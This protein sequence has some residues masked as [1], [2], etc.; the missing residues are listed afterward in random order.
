MRRPPSRLPAPAPGFSLLELSLA[1]GI[2]AALVL[3]AFPAIKGVSAS[4][5]QVTCAQNLRQLGAAL[6]TYM[7]DNQQTL[8]GPQGTQIKM[9][10]NT[11]RKLRPYLPPPD[12]E[13]LGPWECPANTGLKHANKTNNPKVASYL[14]NEQLFGYF[15]ATNVYPTTLP[16]ILERPPAERWLLRDM[17]S[18]NYSSLPAYG[19]QYPPVHRGGRNVLYIDGSVAWV[20]SV[21]NV[22]P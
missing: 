16:R 10:T 21:K 2:V 17:D 15:A 7:Q 13:T 14:A 12:E 11:P 18:W 9:N 6:I 3:L 5:R 8:P 20:R 22:R 1:T 4:S 19:G